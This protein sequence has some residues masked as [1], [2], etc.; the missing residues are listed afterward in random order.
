MKGVFWNC[1]GVGK[2]GMSTCL[3]DMI[4]ANELDFIGLQETM[5]KSYT[6][7]FFR[8]IDPYQKFHWEWIPS[9]GKS[10]GI[11]CGLNKE[12][13]DILTTKCGKYILQ[14]NLFDKNKNCS[15]A[16]MTVYGAAHDEQKPEFIAEL[17]SM[18]HSS[19]IPYLVGGDFNIIR[20]GGEKNKK[21]LCPTSRRCLILLFIYLG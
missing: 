8:Q 17:S 4:S 20:H 1:R 3:I 12:K 10:G 21:H 5:K 7:A 19:N 11:L 6:P 9:R 15:W 13:F 16:L 14:L 18:C 2:K